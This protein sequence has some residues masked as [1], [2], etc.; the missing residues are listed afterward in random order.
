MR[1]R[2]KWKSAGLNFVIKTN[3]F[4]KQKKNVKIRMSINMSIFC[5]CIERQYYES[6]ESKET[7]IHDHDLELIVQGMKQKGFIK[8]HPRAYSKFTITFTAPE[9]FKDDCIR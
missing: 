3:Y 7:E 4:R 1:I 2:I 5:D 6:L 9:E 8:K